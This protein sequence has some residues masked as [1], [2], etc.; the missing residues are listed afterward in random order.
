MNHIPDVAK[1]TDWLLQQASLESLHSPNAWHWLEAAHIVGQ[2]QFLLHSRVHW[3]MLRRATKQD[4]WAEVYAQIMRL[5]LVPLGH[6]S[7]RLPL[8]NPGSSRINAFQ[9][10]PIPAH[11]FILIMQS[12]N[13]GTVQTP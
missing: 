6:M 11:L 8:G 10:M 5:S 12:R 7:Q 3:H 2:T 13:I 4:N 9:P 1:Q